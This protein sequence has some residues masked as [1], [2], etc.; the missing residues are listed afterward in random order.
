MYVLLYCK[1]IYFIMILSLSL[2]CFFPRHMVSM[3]C[4]R[5][6]INAVL[7]PR[8]DTCEFDRGTWLIDCSREEAVERLSGLPHGS[9]LVRPKNKRQ[10]P[11]VL[12]IVYVFSYDAYWIL[13]NCFSVNG[14][15]A[16]LQ[17]VMPLFTLKI[18]S[19]HPTHH[20]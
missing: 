6:F 11:Y 9:F 1:E 4:E 16:L 17:N 5:E 20:T 8:V 7:E 12:S 3:G 15:W 10:F 14:E 19:L 2:T 18:S 13:D